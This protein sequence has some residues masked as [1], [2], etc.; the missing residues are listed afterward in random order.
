VTGEG[1]RI[2]IRA[3]PGRTLTIHTWRGS[4]G[5]CISTV[6]MTV[7]GVAA[8]VASVYVKQR[9]FGISYVLLTGVAQDGTV[10]QERV[11]P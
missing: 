3:L 9:L 1:I 8:R 6:D 11:V 4:S 2:A 5:H 10:V 7:A